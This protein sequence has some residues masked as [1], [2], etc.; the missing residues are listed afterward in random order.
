MAILLR[1]LVVRYDVGLLIEGHSAGSYSALH[2]AYLAA[3]LQMRGITRVKLS[4]AY[5]PLIAVCHVPST[6][7]VLILQR[8]Q[9]ALCH[10]NADLRGHLRRVMGEFVKI[11]HFQ[12]DRDLMRLVR[13][14]VGSSCHMYSNLLANIVFDK[15]YVNIHEINDPPRLFSTAQQAGF[16]IAVANGRLKAA[17]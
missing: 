9:D 3:A 2:I 7:R 15:V 10:M 8:N 1:S 17:P 12:I 14:A 6:V 4:A 5:F 13:P 11:V 16:A